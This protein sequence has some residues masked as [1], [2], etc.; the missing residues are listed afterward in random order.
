MTQGSLMVSGLVWIKQYH[1]IPTL[2]GVIALCSWARCFTLTVPLFTHT[3]MYT[4]VMANLILE[5]IPAI[6]YMEHPIQGSVD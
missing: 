1:K 3:C 4:W 2:A 5:G 6:N